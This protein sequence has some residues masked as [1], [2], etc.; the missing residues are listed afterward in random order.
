[1]QDYVWLVWL[2][3]I[4]LVFWLLIIRPNQQRQKAARELQAS[5]G[6]GDQVMLT[7][8]IY[9][10]VAELGEDHVMVDVAPGTSLKVARGAVAAKLDPEPSG[11]A[12]EESVQPG[13]EG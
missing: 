4:V 6:V 7:S 13:E 10:A 8:G 11:T 5:L 9:A 12:G 2:A 1:M 3:A